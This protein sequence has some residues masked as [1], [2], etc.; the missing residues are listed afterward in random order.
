MSLAKLFYLKETFRE[1]VRRWQQAG[2]RRRTTSLAPGRS[3][4]DSPD[5]SRFT[6]HASRFWLEALEPRL[7]LS[8][9]LTEVVATQALEPAAI[10]VPAGSLPSLDVDLNG[11]ADALS[12]GILIIRHLF[13][14]TGTALAD[15]AVDPAGQRTDP[16]AIANYLNSIRTTALD[17]DLNG[18]ADAL[19]DGILI[20][21]SLFG[22][23]GTA[24]TD[25]VVDP[26]GQR[27]DPAVIATFLDNMNPQRELIAPLMTAGLQQDTGLS[28]SDTITFNPA[29]TGTITDINQIASFTAG[30]DAAPVGSFVNVLTDL[31]P[32]G[33]FTLSAARMNQVAGGTLADGAHTLH[34]RATDARGNVAVVDRLLTLDTTV[35]SATFNLASGSD[36]APIGDLQTLFAVVSL[37]G[38]TEPTAA[39][40]LLQGN[41]TG[42]IDQSGTFSINNIPL[43]LG[44]NALTIRVTDQ[45]GNVA[46]VSKTFTRVPSTNQPPV[47]SPIGNQTVRAGELL[48]VTTSVSDADV[49]AQVLSFSLVGPAPQ[50]VSIGA[51]TGVLT[52]T[53][54]AAQIGQASITVR[55]EDSG[56]LSLSDE[57]TFT[58][59]VA[60]ANQAPVLTPIG[61]LTLFPGGHLEVPFT[62]TDPN[63]DRVQFFVASVSPLPTSML[64]GGGTFII[65]PA[66][67]E[68][69]TY[70]FTVIAS[71]GALTST[72]TVSL[73]VAPDP[74]ATTRIS[75]K[76]VGTTGQP[77]AG[78]PIEVG[79]IITLTAADGTFTLDLPA[80]LVPTASFNIT[81]PNGDIYFD[82]FNTG[83]QFISMRRAGSDPA[84]GTS[85]ANPLQHPNLV[86]SFLDGNI[87][88]G[89]DPDRALALRTLEGGKLKTS[90][91]NLLPFNN[92]TF[93]PNG[94]LP[95]DNAGNAD[96]GSLFVA[97][98]VRASENVAL[99][100]MHTVLLREHNRLADVIA[101]ANPGLSDEGI[102]QQ[103]RRWLVG[104]LQ[105][106]VY[107]EYLPVLLGPN[108]VPAYTGYNVSTDPAVSAIFATAAFRFGHS[109]MVSQLLQLDAAGSPLPGGALNLRDAFFTTAPITADGIDPILRGLLAQQAQDIDT[110]VVDELRN[111]LFGPPG[112]GGQDLVS[113]NI[114][115]GRD[116]GLPSYTQARLDFGLT[117]ITS[118]SQ[119]TSNITVQQM[120]Q[121]VY[122]TVDK[123]D[124]WVGGIAEDHAAGALIGPLFQQIIAD[125]FTRTRNADRFWYENSQ[126][127]ASELVQIR[128]TTFADLLA[129]NTGLTNLPTNVFTTATPPTGPA[130]AG[131]AAATAPAEF[132]SADG[133][134]N[135][136]TDP[137]LGQT[138]SNLKANFT[139][140]YGDGIS[141][142][143]GADRPGAREISNAVFPQTGSIPNTQGA[144]AL[145]VFFG[146]ILDHDLSL[147]A[148]GIT[149]TIKIHGDQ[150]APAGTYPFVA[151][152]LPLMLGHDVYAGLNNVI[153]RPIFLPAIDVA[154]AVTINPATDAIVSTP[155]IPGASVAVAAGTLEDREGNMFAGQ[156]SITQ[157]PSSLTPASL[158]PGLNPDLVVTIQPAEMV[159]TTPAPL[160]LPNSGGFAPGTVMD[161]WSINPLTGQFDNVGKGQVSQD[162]TV[163]ETINGGVR[164]SSWHFFS[165]P[166][167]PNPPEDHSEEC[168]ECNATGGFSSDVELGSGAII[169]SHV[170]PTYQSLGVER[171][172]QLVYDSLRADPNQI[173]Q[174]G[175]DAV[176]FDP[177]AYFVGKL[178]IGYRNDDG[179]F[180]GSTVPGGIMPGQGS[181]GWHF[182]RVPD[183]GATPFGAGV[184]NLEAAIQA[185]LTALPTGLYDYRA[186]YGLHNHRPQ[187]TIGVTT[188][189]ERLVGS[190]TSFWGDIVTVNEVSS[191]F[192]AGWGMAGFQKLVTAG[193]DVILVDGDGSHLLYRAN[194]T[195]EVGT[196]NT[197]ADQRT[198]IATSFTAPP[199]HFA[200]LIPL[201]QDVP[202]GSGFERI[203]T[204]YRQTLTDQTV[205]TFD[206]GGKLLTVQDRNGNTTAYEYNAAGQLT[207]IVDPVGLA[208]TFSYI[209]SR[210][211]TITDPANRITS[212]SYDAAGN[213]I[214]ITDPD[215]TARQ[216][217]YDGRHHIIG[218]TDQRGN[219]E[220][221]FY[222]FAG[223]AASAVRK[224]GGKIT[225]KPRDVL[226]LSNPQLT[227]NWQTAPVAR[228]RTT[229]QDAAEYIAPN[230]N[231]MIA[232]LDDMGQALR[233][234][235]SLGQLSSVVRNTDNLVS[236]TT[237]ALGHV[238]HYSYDTRGNLTSVRDE[239][240]GGSR[241][242]GTL[243]PDSPVAIYFLTLDH[244]TNLFFDSLTDRSDVLWSLF[245]GESAQ[246][247]VPLVSSRPF[248]S[249]APLPKG[250]SRI[251]GLLEP[252][253]Y[254]LFVQGFGGGTD[255]FSFRLIDVDQAIPI[256]LGAPIS[257][258][259]APG[260][261]GDLYRFTASAGDQLSLDAIS[262]A[263]FSAPV[264]W[265]LVDEGGFPVFTQN[266]SD[267]NAVTVPVTG[268]YTLLIEGDIAE[269]TQNGAYSFSVTKVSNGPAA[270]PTTPIAF[271]ATIT[272]TI[273]QVGEID[274][275]SFQV[276]DGTIVYLDDLGTGTNI[277]GALFTQRLGN[278]SLPI[279]AGLPDGMLRN[280]PG[281]GTYTL[282]LSGVAGA[283]GPYQFRL[284]NLAGATPVTAGTA[285]AGMLTPGFETDLYAVN[286]PLD[287]LYQLDITAQ[288]T[289]GFT[290]SP[291]LHLVDQS[292]KVLQSRALPAAGQ[293][294]IQITEEFVF[295]TLYLIIEGAAAASGASGTYSVT[296]TLTPQALPAVPSFAPQQITVGALVSGQ[297][298]GPGEFDQ[299]VVQATFGQRLLFVGVSTNV[300]GLGV[301]IPTAQVN[302]GFTSGAVVGPFTVSQTGGVLISIGGSSATAGT[303]S[304]RVLDLAD[305]KP[306]KLGS[307][308]TG[309]L[310]S[311]TGVEMLSFTG[312]IGQ[313]VT[314]DSLSISSPTARWRLVAPDDRVLLSG[315]L[316]ADLGPATLT[317][318]GTYVLII[319]GGSPSAST[320][321]YSIRADVVTPLAVTASGFGIVSGTV[322]GL[323]FDTYQVTASA[324]TLL[325]LDDLQSSFVEVSIQ[326]STGEFVGGNQSFL[327]G[328]VP[329][330]LP[331]SGTYSVR[332][333]S[334]SLIGFQFPQDYRFRILNI[335]ND[336]TAIT[337]GN[338]IS[339]QFAAGESTTAF[340][341]TVTAGQRLYFDDLVPPGSFFSRS[342]FAADGTSIPFQDLHRFV[343]PGTYYLLA[344]P[345]S[346][347]QPSTLQ[348]RLLDLATAPGILF[349]R[350]VAATSATGLA[351]Q[352]YQFDVTSAQTARVKALTTSE[353]TSAKWGLT[354][355]STPGSQAPLTD[356]FL[357]TDVTPGTYWLIVDGN[358]GTPFSYSF[359]VTLMPTPA[360]GIPQF[361]NLTPTHG[362]DNQATGQ[363]TQ[364]T[365]DAVFS[366]VT[367]I[368]DEL[369]HQTLLDIDPANGNIRSITSVVGAVG[370]G[371]DVTTQLTY[372][373]QGLVDLVTDPLGRV[374]DY[375]YNLLGRLI[376]LTY[377]KGT[378]DQGVQQ[379]EYDAAGN[380]TA[381]I[382]ENNHRTEFAYDQM[383]RLTLTRDPF[384]H[385]TGFAYDAAG[386]LIRTT[387]ARTNQ[388]NY[389]YDVLNRRFSMTDA[390]NG[391]TEFAY[392]VA[393]TVVSATDPLGHATTYTYDLRGRLVRTI[394]SAG[395]TT[396]FG[397]D[398]NNNLTSLI[399]PVG[400]ATVSAYDARDRM[401][402]ETD[403]LGHATRYHYDSVDNV[404]G[405]IDRNGQAMAYAYDDLD[406]LNTETWV[407]GG[408]VVTS[409]YDKVGNLTSFFDQFSTLAFTYDNR[410]RVKTVDN[411]GTPNGPRVALSYVYDGAGNI[412]AVAD[413][414][415][416]AAAGTNAYTYDA[417]NRTTRVTQSGAGVADKRVDFSYNEVSQFASVS[418]FSS[419][420]GGQAVATTNYNYDALNRITNMTHTNAANAMLNQFQIEYDPAS[421]ITKTTDIDGATDY[422][423]DARDQ[424]TGADHAAAGNLDETYQYDENG[425]RVASGLH[426]SG[427][428]TGPGNRLVSDGTFNY[429]YD[430]KGSLVRRTVIATGAVREFTYDD[431]TRLVEIDDYGSLGGPATQTVKLAYDVFNRRISK[432]VDPD[433]AGPGTGHVD[434]FGYDGSDVILEFRDPD[435]SG[436]A[437]TT[438]TRRNLFGPGADHILATQDSAGS[439]MWVLSDQLGSVRDL[440][441][442]GGVVVNHIAYDSFGN[443]VAQTN[444]ARS[445]RYLFTGREYDDETGIYYYRSRYYDPSLG[446]FMSED[447]IGFLGQDLNLYSYVRGNPVGLRDPEGLTP[448]IVTLSAREAVGVSSLP[449]SSNYPVVGQIGKFSVSGHGNEAGDRLVIINEDP[450]TGKEISRK[451]L[452]GKEVADLIRKDKDYKP[453]NRV[454]LYVCNSGKKLAQ[455]VATE[456]KSGQVTGP[457]GPIKSY[458]NQST[459][460]L[461]SG[462]WA[463]FN[464]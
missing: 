205:F 162:G 336:S 330:F 84:T 294:P 269:T 174:I 116:M 263:V 185:D 427:Y 112:S 383:D 96:P 422:N 353:V 238:T 219:R 343:L 271:G 244:Y 14:F 234:F 314:L 235:D 89:S 354:D 387:D 202:S 364:F 279:A 397:Y 265:Q 209:G 393:D 69:G 385:E 114:Q 65:T 424:L 61:P 355:G 18:G 2:F 5:V 15:G 118:F 23:T 198:P 352:L 113:L 257:G 371:D 334:S 415:N 340:R 391:I 254:T 85:T 139:V 100:A 8:A 38:Q 165:P 33:S 142:P 426:G 131:T 406:R 228:D 239:L 120:L 188:L 77:L 344:A 42:A 281:P 212:L 338:T 430:G 98:D 339:H 405:M 156:L 51:S 276:Q 109:Q 302:T 365:Y 35:P 29:I 264:T 193:L 190:T 448:N 164:N 404:I 388:T 45:A 270:L 10:T 76:V 434:Y 307:V 412:L 54:T 445:S 102:Y 4:L 441:D 49:P 68:E 127:T 155:A 99:E 372:T 233:S 347:P 255:E 326:A 74:T 184:G 78:V 449:A 152:K 253:G 337:I 231:V 418:R 327:N 292:G 225:L 210:V 329:V 192:G 359:S 438:L 346:F 357:D 179:T 3:S 259:L 220:E 214:R 301:E 420:A 374:T 211:S 39:V 435:G 268:T 41:V 73:T 332:I 101:V 90:A 349:N 242:F 266:F 297:V 321:A 189:P 80:I 223:R 218:E 447:P 399:D 350:T 369:G 429:V 401:V 331:K 82:P 367:S 16:A 380:I 229:S 195:G 442:N 410:D 32:T 439:T 224:D 323:G 411:Q 267:I 83:T 1:S 315:S 187:E 24:L 252:G 151:E 53:P 306:L 366:Q 417:L 398:A 129:R 246:T 221:T 124:A 203:L 186:T 345:N 121:S 360:Q 172:V 133:S 342:V 247:G 395:G 348:F 376:Q 67:G 148:T 28:A 362:Q 283:T 105:H 173:I 351:A 87:V 94:P 161:L 106:I 437:G 310:N 62:A 288:P 95:N 373:A 70:T 256:P 19:S 145:A 446:R 34:L 322:T 280:L 43:V 216:W 356:P 363:G 183:F 262:S 230:G 175:Q 386:N 88:Y 409:A 378:T 379:F 284:L 425:N 240:S 245:G 416:G 452:N 180:T 163:I 237:D 75:G 272:G 27:T 123:I 419:L 81:I 59:T 241:V 275:F 178:E 462:K 52:W 400:N 251:L 6:L 103:A 298:E 440:V 167:M 396:R 377:A 125:Q 115:R 58:V 436:P 40:T 273:G 182:W 208:T 194:T 286:V 110:H 444:S 97:G 258:T 414:I 144:T 394:D 11:Q 138:G 168:E 154:N 119:I 305:A 320:V 207:R 104:E 111:F 407:G 25:G 243:T 158:P 313:Q 421:R 117:P 457:T 21:R 389:G 37:T 382:D 222:D 453:G 206:A 299:Y 149:D 9:T 213:L 316:S 47:F 460:I 423:Y 443:V 375:D 170:L 227:S 300:G 236:E 293:P 402:R 157:V 12:D 328:Y 63:G 261:E 31:L 303:Y 64:N 333:S 71:D 30:F 370:G 277:Q 295:G 454:I 196:F 199:G 392:D 260:N 128:S 381:F 181:T 361:I 309:Q 287:G 308:K 160:N 248:S 86:T 456:L 60:N 312:T 318:D 169:E 408:N 135:N 319:E 108:A 317:L 153:A 431:R 143:G 335:T 304:F 191:P 250:G 176:S 455:D 463:T 55:V 17:V 291:V 413:A 403:P 226:G 130:P 132:R 147:T 177:S 7:L 141:T 136:Q 91:G 150:A 36:T 57:K 137:T 249:T 79:R 13:G 134:G 166:P 48:R 459:P 296:P 217:D 50:G 122:G 200:T 146:Q 390:N 464:P 197:G 311:G 358:Q 282:A 290:A 215:A 450:K 341:V 26:G 201:F 451:E 66:P 274:R 44:G 428:V 324:G 92:T 171:G 289:S 126:F 325:Y 159:F 93:F 72:Q 368:T 461:E 22:F 20:I 46:D 433:G 432:S 204:G 107:S 458:S 232:Q 285:I 384:L 278:S 140:S 56:V